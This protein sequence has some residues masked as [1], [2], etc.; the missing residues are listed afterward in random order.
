MR[1][2]NQKVLGVPRQMFGGTP[3]MRWGYPEV[4]LGVP[5]QR[6]GGTPKMCWGYPENALGV[7]QTVPAA[8]SGGGTVQAFGVAEMA[9]A[10]YLIRRGREYYTKILG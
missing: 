6:F 2:Q 8:G 4:V 7:A 10:R 9:D 1:G 5:R 3:K